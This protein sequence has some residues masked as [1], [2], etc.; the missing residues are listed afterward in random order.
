MTQTFD[1]E[2]VPLDVKKQKVVD[3]LRQTEPES[4]DVGRRHSWDNPVFGRVK[5]ELVFHHDQLFKIT[6][7]NIDHEHGQAVRCV[8]NYRDINGALLDT[9]NFVP[10]W[11]PRVGASNR[12]RWRQPKG[13]NIKSREWSIWCELPVNVEVRYEL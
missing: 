13:R 4:I 11:Q 8:L 10:I 1:P 2:R 3:I 9:T 5:R 12:C 6:M 7:V